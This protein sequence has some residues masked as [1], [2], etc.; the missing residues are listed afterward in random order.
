[1]SA[2]PMVGNE[3][4]TYSATTNQGAAPVL[5]G[6]RAT[7]GPSGV[8]AT[9]ALAGQLIELGKTDKQALKAQL[10]KMDASEKEKLVNM[11]REEMERQAKAA[12]AADDEIDRMFGQ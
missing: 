11:M 2:R 12:Q 10:L 4:S 7:A 6:A 9:Q 8:V 5:T 1:M 3:M